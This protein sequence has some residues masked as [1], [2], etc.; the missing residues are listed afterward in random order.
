LIWHGGE[1]GRENSHLNF[2]IDT[3]EMDVLFM[4]PACGVYDISYLI[5]WMTEAVGEMLALTEFTTG[6]KVANDTTKTRTH[7]RCNLI[8]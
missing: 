3:Q 8:F 5:S 6:D 7:G 1:T 2:F 4:L